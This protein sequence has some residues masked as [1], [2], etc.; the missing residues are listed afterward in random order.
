MSSTS[1][2]EIVNRFCETTYNLFTLEAF[3]KKLVEYQNASQKAKREEILAQINIAS[4]VSDSVVKASREDNIDVQG[5]LYG[6][7]RSYS[8]LDVM[9]EVI[10]EDLVAF[11]DV[12]WDL[13]VQGCDTKGRRLEY[14]KA[15]VLHIFRS[16]PKKRIYRANILVTTPEK[17][18]CYDV[19]FN[20]ISIF[21]ESFV[22]NEE[23]Q[24]FVKLSHTLFFYQSRKLKDREQREP[25]I[26]A[27]F[28]VLLQRYVDNT[29]LHENVT[30]ETRQKTIYDKLLENP[31]EYLN[32][33]TPINSSLVDT[34]R[35][36][37]TNAKMLDRWVHEQKAIKVNVSEDMLY[38]QGASPKVAI[39]KI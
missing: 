32:A 1:L 39:I 36:E 37:Y 31:Y 23:I 10:N 18:D 20:F 5:L 13:L 11:L 35:A 8:E 2:C 19:L 34:V 9:R 30:T 27:I 29:R 6:R 14:V 24:R 16:F 4:S 17:M 3:Y 22:F 21:M 26:L 15:I 38:T 7:I 25:V 12:L 28:K 33:I